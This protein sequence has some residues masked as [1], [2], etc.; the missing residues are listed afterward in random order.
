MKALYLIIGTQAAL[1]VPFSLACP[2]SFKSL[3][4]TIGC[5]MTAG[6]C[7]VN[8]W[9]YTSPLYDENENPVPK[10]AQPKTRRFFGKPS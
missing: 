3:L 9:W 6:L 5:L 4:V 10:A 2:L 8:Y 1:I 7:L